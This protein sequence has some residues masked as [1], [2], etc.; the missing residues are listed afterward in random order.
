MRELDC[1]KKI[2]VHNEYESKIVDNILKK[3]KSWLWISLCCF[4]CQLLTI[5]LLKLF[6]I[7]GTLQSLGVLLQI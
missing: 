2:A 6:S 3:I 1:I 4:C 5:D 7:L